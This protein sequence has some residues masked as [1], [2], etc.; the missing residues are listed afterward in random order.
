MKTFEEL[1][2]TFLSLYTPPFYY[3]NQAQDV[4][5]DKHHQVLDIRGWGR[6]GY[7]PNGAKLQDEVGEYICQLLNKDAK[8]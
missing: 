2:K 3:N 5:D 1:R 7:L 4:R 8:D 6:L